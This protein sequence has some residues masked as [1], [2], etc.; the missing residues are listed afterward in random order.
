MLTRGCGT[1]SWCAGRAVLLTRAC[2][3]A[4]SCAGRPVL[5]T[6]ACGT[7]PSCAGWAVWLTGACDPSLPQC[8]RIRLP[9]W[10]R[11]GGLGFVGQEG[12][13]GDGLVEGWLVGVGVLKPG[14]MG[15]PALPQGDVVLHGVVDAFLQCPFLVLCAG[16][17]ACDRQRGDQDDCLYFHVRKNLVPDAKLTSAGKNFNSNRRTPAFHR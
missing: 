10:R 1:A 7:A 17:H 6:G 3:T 2:G 12:G 13:A 14:Q 11:L 16:G 5:L 4:P 15:V 8:S 9:F